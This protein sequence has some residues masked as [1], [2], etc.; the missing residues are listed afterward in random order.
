MV[1]DSKRWSS[2]AILTTIGTG[3]FA[4][5]AGA[6]QSSENSIR[7]TVD[8]C[9]TA[10]VTGAAVLD[11]EGY[12]YQAHLYGR[13]IYHDNTSIHSRALQPL[14]FPRFEYNVEENLPFF[15]DIAIIRWIDI[16]DA[17]GN[18]I[19]RAAPPDGVECREIIDE[20]VG[21]S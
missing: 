3:A 7:L 18:V 19:R 17:E 10:T 1:D 9:K 13:N 15:C 5:V 14:P 12:Q 11:D 21:S 4:G 2:R 20:Q 6:Q 8:D 16:L